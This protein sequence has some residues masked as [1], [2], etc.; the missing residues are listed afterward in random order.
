MIN[1]EILNSLSEL[2]LNDKEARVYIAMLQLGESP[3]IPIAH[4]AGIKRTTVY[5]YLEDF[6]R[7]GLISLSTKN[8]RKHYIAN[9]PTRLQELLEDRSRKLTAVLPNLFSLYQQDETK[10]SVQMFE[11]LEGIKT[12][13]QLSLDN[14]E[15]RL[16]VIPV[17]DS[18]YNFVGSDYIESY[19][20]KSKELSIA[21][22][23]IRL[24][25]DLFEGYGYA[26][27]QTGDNRHIRIAPD[28]FVPQSYMHIYDDKVATFS[29]TKEVPY[30]IV[31]T[32]PSF[33][34]SMRL[35]YESIW[36][37]S[38]PVTNE[39]LAKPAELV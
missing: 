6:L 15:K 16:D 4:L 36:E 32:S 31:T 28:W 9:S 21:I 14:H 13:L 10:P 5:N 30:A 27:L 24:S 19:I 8:N 23:S 26:D 25:K 37:Q 1:Q 38:R 17:M 18:G 2:G 3:I 39:P 29:Q 12:V 11:G 35:F 20:A 33:A 22:R 34:Q 7:L